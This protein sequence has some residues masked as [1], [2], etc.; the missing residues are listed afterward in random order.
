MTASTSDTPAARKP[1]G[2]GWTLYWAVVWGAIGAY[3]LLRFLAH[4]STGHL[5]P[6]PDYGIPLL[7]GSFLACWSRDLGGMHG[8]RWGM[9]VWAGWFV[10]GAGYWVVG[11]RR[12]ALILLGVLV[13]LYAAGLFFT[14]FRP[15]VLGD[16]PFYAVGQ[17][18]SGM[19]FAMLLFGGP[20]HAHPRAGWSVS[21]F[22]A[23]ML[24]VAAAG[25][26]N[27]LSVLNLPLAA[28]KAAPL[29]TEEKA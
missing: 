15:V 17:Y 16:Q 6:P 23:G 20:E 14:G 26:L 29:A 9:A 11:R 4:L 22:D 21:W 7:V 18:G 13:L 1:P 10:P 19:T 27:F 3:E 8:S 2:G 24:C 12:R 5:F 25:I 28:A